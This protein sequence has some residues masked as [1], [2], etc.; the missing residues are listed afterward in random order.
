MKAQA[1]VL[2]GDGHR[3]LTPLARCFLC[4]DP[5]LQRT[6]EDH[7]GALLKISIWAGS[8]PIFADLKR[9]YIPRKIGCKKTA[10]SRIPCSS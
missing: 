2:F 5:A 10:I 4:R 8:P 6:S 7:D 3:K 9:C 1:A